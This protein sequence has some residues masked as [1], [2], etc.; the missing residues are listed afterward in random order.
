MFIC[1]LFQEIRSRCQNAQ[2]WQFVEHTRTLELQCRDNNRV[3]HTFSWKVGVMDQGI[4][5]Q[6]KKDLDEL[7]NLCGEVKLL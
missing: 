6:L 1:V 2:L 3:S 4:Y 7:R 5:S